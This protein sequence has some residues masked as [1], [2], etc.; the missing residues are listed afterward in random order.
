VWASLDDLPNSGLKECSDKHAALDDRPG[1]EAFGD[2]PLS[3]HALLTAFDNHRFE[4]IDVLGLKFFAVT[5]QFL[6]IWIFTGARSVE[7]DLP[8]ACAAQG[9][10]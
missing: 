3:V 9:V 8:K 2:M 5:F 4:L 1:R 10:L 6:K 7:P